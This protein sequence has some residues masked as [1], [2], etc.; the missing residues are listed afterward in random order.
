MLQ[1]CFCL[2]R[3]VLNDSKPALTAD[4]FLKNYDILDLLKE[5]GKTLNL[6][7]DGL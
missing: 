5:H 1:I 6:N 7:I 2:L 4:E 3:G